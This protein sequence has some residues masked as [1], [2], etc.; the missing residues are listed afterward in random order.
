MLT[1]VALA[2]EQTSALSTHSEQHVLALN[3]GSSSLKFGLYRVC[4]EALTCLLRGHAEGWGGGTMV[5]QAQDAHGV[6]VLHDSAMMTNAADAIQRIQPLLLHQQLPGPDAIGHRIVH[7]GQQVREHCLI[8]PAV[9]KAL[10]VAGALAPLHAPAA[11]TGIKQATANFGGLPQVAC[12]DTSFHAHMPLK[13]C[14]L[15]LPQELRMAGLVRYGFHGLSCESI[16]RQLS[17]ALPQR[18]LIAHLGNGASITAVQHGQSIDT[19]M[20]LTPTGGLIMGTRSGNLDPGVLVYLMRSMR[21]DAAALE[22]LVNHRCGLLA[23]SGLSSDMRLLHAAAASKPDAQLAIEMF[24][25]AVAKELGAMSVALG[26]VDMIVFTGGIGEHDAQVRAQVCAQ[27]S[28]LGVELDDALNQ[29][30]LK[31]VGVGVG[32]TVS[33]QNSRCA[34][35]VLPSQEDEQIALHTWRLCHLAAVAG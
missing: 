3:C 35:Q 7:G 27:L 1:P 10:E 33:H 20:G 4:G 26:G 8:T 34:V 16:V 15:P 12:L 25:Y 13:A 32:V 14:S 28:S 22:D 21:L 2:K 30:G 23:L 19:S 6:I 9:I 31:G 11:L 17:R 5:F 24:S 18:L 29:Q